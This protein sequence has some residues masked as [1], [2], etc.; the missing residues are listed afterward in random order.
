ME[1]A[2]TLSAVGRY[3][4]GACLDGLNQGSSRQFLGH[5]RLAP[6]TTAREKPFSALLNNAP[7]IGIAFD[8]RAQ[9]GSGL[10]Q[11]YLWWQRWHIRVGNKLH[12]Y[13]ASRR[14]R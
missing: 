11:R 6:H 14:R 9:I 10:I 1:G 8:Q 4:I 13:G 3:P 5:G 12:R 7:R 2:I